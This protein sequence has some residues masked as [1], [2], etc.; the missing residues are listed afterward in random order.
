MEDPAMSQKTE[1]EI[2]ADLMA[3]LR[4]HDVCLAVDRGSGTEWIR[5]SGSG[6][7]RADASGRGSLTEAALRA[8]IK[9]NAYQ[10]VPLATA[11]P[12]SVTTS[13]WEDS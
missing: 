2:V 3:Y 9:A 5:A 1:A 12:A 6:W 4:A 13:I 7:E 11:G 10:V 8:I